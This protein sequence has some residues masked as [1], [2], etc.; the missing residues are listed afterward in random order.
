MK[1]DAISPP[2]RSDLLT[3]D[4][5]IAKGA[6]G[7]P[8]Q[9]QVVVETRGITKRFPGV[10]ANSNIGFRGRRGEIHTVL[11]ENGAGKTTLMNILSGMIQPD[12]GTLFIRG[13]EVTITSPQDALKRGIGTVYQHFTLVPNLSVIE[14]VILGMDSGFILDLSQA[15]RRLQ[16]MLGAFGMAVSPLTEV[17]YLSI[18]QQQRVEIIKVLFRGSEV[19]LLDEPTSVLTPSEVQE[20]FEILIRLKAEG[21][22]VVFITHKLEE[23]LEISDRITVLRAGKKVGDFGPNDLTHHPAVTSQRIVDLMFGGLPAEETASRLIKPPGKTTLTLRNIT[24]LGDRG[25]PAVRDVSLELHA[26]EILGIAGVDGNGQK[27]LGEVIAGQRQ[28]SKGQVITNGVDITNRG[29]SVAA[30]MGIGYITDD[31]MGEGCVPSLSVAEN[32]VLKVA[33]RHPFSSRAVL[34]RPAIEAYARRLIQEYDIKAAGPWVPTSTLSGGNIQKL[35]LA[36]ELALNP[37]V[38][39]CNKPTHGLDVKTARFVLQTLRAQAD[40]GATVI[41]ISSELDE[42]MELSDRIGVMYNGRILDIFP[43]DRADRETIGRLMLGVYQ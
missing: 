43:Q 10:V 13:Q 35:L 27:E 41:L 1:V 17:R 40:E 32:L 39:V 30:E 36:R 2:S 11:G 28:A 23:A 31:R 18:G 5:P 22:A 16:G 6:V 33:D 8:N 24:A 25:T 12:A 4:E 37:K 21:V 29:I 7:S 42:I 9:G 14:N 3:T 26:G 15:E 20:L 38:L 34:N 19:L